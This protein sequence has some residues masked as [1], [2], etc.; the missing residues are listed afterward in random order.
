MKGLKEYLIID[1]YN[2]INSWPLLREI[3]LTD[4]DDA[5]RQLIDMMAEYQS[6]K[7]IRVMIVFDAHLVKHSR[8]KKEHVKGVEVVFTKEK[9]TADGFIE[10]KINELSQRNRVM[11][12]T[13][14]WMEQQMVL[15]S[16]AT[17]ISVREL[18]LDYQYIK[19]KI[20]KKTEDLKY[21]KDYLS[22]RL[23]ENLLEKL[24]KFRRKL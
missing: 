2:V 4:L 9:E 6:Y 21:K 7:A 13:N 14:D 17:R 24:E 18:V 15:G 23:D 8:E 11:V 1:G 3:C 19:E 5:R 22:N 20:T 12:V 10:K 16:G